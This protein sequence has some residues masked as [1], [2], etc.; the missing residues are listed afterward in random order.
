MKPSLRTLLL[1]LLLALALRLIALGSRTLWYDEAFAVLFSEKGLDAM[2]YGTLTPVNGSAA[3]VHPLLYYTTLNGWMR[4]FGQS[5]TAVRLYSVL[6]G[7]LTV[8]VLYRLGRELFG[9]RTGLTAAFI[10]AVAPFHVQYSQEARMYALLGLLLAAATWCF[11]R[12]WRT[13]RIRYWIGFGLLAGLG[14]YAQQLAAFY[15]VTLGLLPF[16][17]RRRKPMIHVTLG[18]GLALVIYLPWLAYLPSQFGKIST[19]WV[20]RPGVLQPLVTLW[21][22][23][24]ADLE[25]RA[26][27]VVV[28]SLTALSVLLVFLVYCALKVLR[29]PNPDR[30]PLA[31]VLALTA[32]P[33]GLMWLVSQWRPVY[34]T[35]A[36]L[37]SG[38]MFYLAL[39]WLLARAR[40]PR[41][42]RATLAVLWLATA[43]VGLDAQYTWNT[44]PRPPFDAADSF[45]AAHWQPGDRVVHANK[46]TML[47]MTYYDRS[48]PQAYVRDT[49]G[50][51]EDTLARPTQ[52]TLGLLADDCTAAAAKGSARVWF[53]IFQQQIDQQG[54]APPSRD[55]LDT[56]YRRVSLD[57]FNDLLVY[58][59]DQPDEAARKA[60]CEAS[61]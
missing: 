19:Y 54:G 5:P 43:A 53:I 40:L 21:S 45:I 35:R 26:A 11:V 39:A 18:A 9:E 50:S 37:P 33:I 32:G 30:A 59:Y 7:L 57:S 42:I 61:P 14:M 25:V 41:P 4:L 56:H 3:D 22:F 2:L 23:L 36:L 17:V 29:R 6:I 58:L 47:P 20:Q 24:F 44:F 38:L 49:P 52:E 27:P 1:I 28:L 10:T 15:L 48:L 16:L 51:G 31:L 60:R 13:G 8:A 12:G 34:L 46:I 55:W